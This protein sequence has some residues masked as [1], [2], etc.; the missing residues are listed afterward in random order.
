MVAASSPTFQTL[1]TPIV[2]SNAG[3]YQGVQYGNNW[4]LFDT[5]ASTGAHALSA[6]CLYG[7]PG[8]TPSLSYGTWNSG[9]QIYTP[10]ITMNPATGAASLAGTLTVGGNI[11]LTGYLYGGLAST[12]SAG[13][14]TSSSGNT[15]HVSGPNICCGAGNQGPNID[16]NTWSSAIGSTLTKQGGI[17]INTDS[18]SHYGIALDFVPNNGAGTLTH[19]I[20]ASDYSSGSSLSFMNGLNNCPLVGG[21]C[22]G[23]NST[24]DAAGD[25][26]GKSLSLSGSGC[27]P[28][29]Y[30]K[31]DGSGCGPGGVSPAITIAPSDSPQTGATITLTGSSDQT[32]INTAIDT[33]CA[34][35]NVST[36][37]PG[38]DITILYGKVNVTG[39]IVI[40]RSD[41]HLHGQG[42]STYGGV[43]SA[44]YGGTQ[45]VATSDSEK[46]S[47]G[48][49]DGNDPVRGH[50]KRHG[51]LPGHLHR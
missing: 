13:S 14:F 51:P 40:N 18:T 22:F 9:T 25:I 6:L 24:I 3:Y 27:A 7:G 30:A 2:G 46:I 36:D 8:N 4:C 12:G 33:Y 44:S 21:M 29:T 11:N 43:N 32:E 26:T 37:V 39:S 38:C 47:A 31:A 35:D 50:R 49:G 19:M 17:G 5:G 20:W 34:P 16:F 45:I 28:G 48:Y 1:S 10:N 42:F 41:V 15:W 23:P